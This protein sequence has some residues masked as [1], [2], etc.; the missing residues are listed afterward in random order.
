MHAPTNRVAEDDFDDLDDLDH[1]QDILASLGCFSGMS[2]TH[3]SGFCFRFY[4][5]DVRKSKRKS[6]TIETK[7]SVL[8]KLDEFQ[9]NKSKTAKICGVPRQSVQDWAKEREKLQGIRDDRSL[10]VKRRRKIPLEKDDTKRRR[11]FPLDK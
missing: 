5:R 4:R 7:L 11:V 9:G 6:Y 2:L 3:V 8:R 10:S 1:E